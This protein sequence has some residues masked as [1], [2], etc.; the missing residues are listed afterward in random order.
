MQT[1]GHDNPA[2]TGSR[3]VP[4][5]VAFAQKTVRPG[6]RAPDLLFQVGYERVTKGGRV[7]A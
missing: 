6:L 2:A 1:R 7:Q 4:A 5:T 3:K